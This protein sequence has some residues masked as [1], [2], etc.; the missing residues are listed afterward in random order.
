LGQIGAW[1]DARVVPA[2]KATLFALLDDEAADRS[3]ADQ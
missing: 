1:N 2:L 3:Q